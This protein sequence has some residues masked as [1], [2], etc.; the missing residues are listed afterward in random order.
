MPLQGLLKPSCKGFLNKLI[1]GNFMSQNIFDF[2]FSI[3]KERFDSGRPTRIPDV[4]VMANDAG[5]RTRK[6]KTYQAGARGFYRV[7]ADA[8]R[9]FQRK[10]NPEYW[11]IRELLN[12]SGR[13]SWRKG[14]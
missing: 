14:K 12:S 4:T 1:I 3:A 6:G 10:G 13:Y 5:F 8:C 9:F 2:I 7:V 11:K